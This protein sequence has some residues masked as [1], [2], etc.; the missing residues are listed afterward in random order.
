MT[1]RETIEKLE[2]SN[3]TVYLHL[4]QLGYVNK[5]HVWVFRELKEIH[6]TKHINICD[7]LLNRNQN[8]SFLKRII[9]GDEKWIIYHNVVR[10][11]SWTK[12]YVSP[13]STSKSSIHQKNIML[14]VW[15][16]YNSVVYFQLLPRNQTVDS[17][18]YCRQLLK[19]NKE[20][21]KKTP[22]TGQLQRCDV[23]SWEH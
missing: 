16:V 20:I 22:W 6:L 21:K 12:K 2:I 15:R 4:Q 3:S 23:P 17:N 1:T 11:R 13:Q 19:L 5:L 8:D 7:S 18:V 9:T 14:S 10:K